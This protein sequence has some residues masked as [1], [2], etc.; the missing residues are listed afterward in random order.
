MR[1]GYAAVS[2]ED[3]QCPESYVKCPNSYCIPT[4]YL[5]N[6]ELDCPLGEDEKE[7]GHLTGETYTQLKDRQKEIRNMRFREHVGNKSLVRTHFETCALTLKTIYLLFVDQAG[8]WSF[9]D[10]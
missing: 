9:V 7:R 8:W 1:H 4:H 6:G 3:F 2:T 10:S 5:V